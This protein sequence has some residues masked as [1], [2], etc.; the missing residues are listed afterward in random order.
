MIWDVLI[1]YRTFSDEMFRDWDVLCLAYLGIGCL[2][3]GR[4]VTGLF[5]DGMF[6]DWMF[7]DGMFSDGTYCMSTRFRYVPLCISYKSCQNS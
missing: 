7:I 5:S 3:M 1:L 6:S 4:L 2:V